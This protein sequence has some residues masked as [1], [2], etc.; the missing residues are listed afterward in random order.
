LL[1]K[2]LFQEIFRDLEK[3]LAIVFGQPVKLGQAETFASAVFV[4]WQV[5]TG[6]EKR[7]WGAVNQ[8]LRGRAARLKC[9]AANA[10]STRVAGPSVREPT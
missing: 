4:I 6:H 5:E 9:Y 1:G 10:F 8:G 2:R 3:L 7:L